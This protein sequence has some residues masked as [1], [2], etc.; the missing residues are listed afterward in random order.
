MEDNDYKKMFE[1]TASLGRK[2]G[3]AECLLAV[4]KLRKI[5]EGDNDNKKFSK[6]FSDVALNTIDQVV[7]LL[8]L[9]QSA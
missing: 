9:L 3:I 7:K 6:T 5:Y 8:E 2:A 4:L 1:T